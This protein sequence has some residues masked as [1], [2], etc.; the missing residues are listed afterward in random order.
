MKNVPQSLV[1]RLIPSA[2]SQ[3]ADEESPALIRDKQVLALKLLSAVD[4]AEV[5]PALAGSSEGS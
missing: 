4:I 1:R 3:A 5:L 2:G